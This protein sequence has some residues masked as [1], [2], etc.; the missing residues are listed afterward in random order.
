MGVQTWGKHYPHFTQEE[1][2]AQVSR[3]ESGAGCEAVC[4]A[5]AQCKP[6]PACCQ[7]KATWLRKSF[8][9]LHPILGEKAPLNKGGRSTV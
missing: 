3:P 2:E 9:S 8:Q 7:H 1:S 6:L 4:K 5:G